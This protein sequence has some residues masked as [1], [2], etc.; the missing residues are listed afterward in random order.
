MP[1][2]GGFATA[3][4][5]E[6]T[7]LEGFDWA[8]NAKGVDR[9]TVEQLATCDFVRRRENVILVGQTGLGK[10]RILQAMGHAACVLGYRVRYATSAKLLQEFTAALADGT[11]DSDARRLRPIGSVAD[12]RIRLRPPGARGSSSG[13]HVLLSPA[14]RPHG[15]AFDGVGDQ[16]RLRSLGRLPRRPAAGDGVS[17]P[18]GRRGGD[19][20]AHRSILPRPSRPTRRRSRLTTPLPQAHASPSPTKPIPPSPRRRSNALT[21]PTKHA[22]TIRAATAQVVPTGPKELRPPGPKLTTAR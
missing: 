16:H 8:F 15:P 21:A 12:R 14:R 20:E 1:W 18:P 11:F 6:L 22:Q 9:R 13:Q 7:T 2:S 4:F 17:R 3:K 5:R 10:S 19:P